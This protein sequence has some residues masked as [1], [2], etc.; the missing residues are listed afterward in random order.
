MNQNEKNYL[1]IN[2]M[3]S[4]DVS[5]TFMSKVF[6]WMCIA[7]GITALTAFISASSPAFFSM[8][9]TQD[10][11]MSLLGWVVTLAP[12]ILVFVMSARVDRMSKGTMTAIF[13]LYSVLMGMSLSFIFFAYSSAVIVK[14][15]LITAGMFGVMAIAGFTTKTDLTKF[16]RIMFM[17]LIGLIIATLV[18]LFTKSA[19]FDYIISFI[20]VLIFTGLTAFDVQK[21]KQIGTMNMGENDTVTKIAIYGALSLYLDFINLFLYLLR[22]FGSRD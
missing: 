6:L 11:R 4:A 9:F 3:E 15:F 2:E 14:T 16:G 17:G 22:I 8:L 5:R 19:M 12:L 18:N 10:G 7:L 1:N 13:V 21:L 20:G